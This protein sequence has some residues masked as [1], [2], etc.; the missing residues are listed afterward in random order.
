MVSYKRVGNRICLVS[1]GS[2]LVKIGF[3]LGVSIPGHWITLFA[4]SI[5]VTRVNK[6]K[7]TDPEK[8]KLFILKVL[9]PE[10]EKIIR[11]A[12]GYALI[13]KSFEFGFC[14]WLLHSCK[15]PFIFLMAATWPQ[16]TVHATHDL[17]AK[18]MHSLYTYMDASCIQLSHEIVIM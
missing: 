6:S 14:R 15:L 16:Y 9:P 18:L 12:K 3:D 7:L 13:C 11:G 2:S 1:A 17:M 4:S 5:S 8:A 10:M